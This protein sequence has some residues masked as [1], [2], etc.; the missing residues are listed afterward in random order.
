MAERWVAEGVAEGDIYE[1]SDIELASRLS[2]FL[3]SS[4]PDDELVEIAAA[5]QLSDPAVLEQ[6][7]AES[8]RRA[9][10]A[11]AAAEEAAEQ[12]PAEEGAAEETV[13][14]ETAEEAP[15]PRAG[16]PLVGALRWL[17]WSS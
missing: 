9:E 17:P 15:A 10:E 13:G 7:I 2:F 1:V 3:W 8:R 5:N 11:G 4:I 6:R 12:P 16:M 14:A